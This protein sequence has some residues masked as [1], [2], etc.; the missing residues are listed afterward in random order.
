MSTNRALKTATG[1][2]QIE[3][4][5]AVPGRPACTPFESPHYFDGITSE[6][7]VC[8]HYS[9]IFVDRLANDESIKRVAVVQGQS[10]QGSK[11]G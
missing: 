7:G 9:Q 1:A 5:H 11:M 8:G 10:F 6:L 3:R 4:Y 2:V